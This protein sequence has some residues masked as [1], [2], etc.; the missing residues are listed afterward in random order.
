MASKQFARFAPGLDVRLT[1]QTGR[2]TAASPGDPAAGF[3]PHHLEYSVRPKVLAGLRYAVELRIHGLHLLNPLDFLVWSPARW[4]WMY[5]E[6]GGP[7]RWRTERYRSFPQRLP[8][9][10]LELAPTKLEARARVAG[11]RSAFAPEFHSLSDE[12]L[13]W[14]SFLPV[15]RKRAA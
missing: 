2:G 3:S 6:K 7:N 11:V 15:I 10:M 4:Q 12:D 14:L 8:T 5:S 1:G 13:S 9:D